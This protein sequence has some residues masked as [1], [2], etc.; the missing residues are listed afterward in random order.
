MS[1]NPRPVDDIVPRQSNR[2]MIGEKK[3]S[4]VASSSA[5]IGTEL[6]T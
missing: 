1:G 2:P 3:R 5:F 4:A 6:F